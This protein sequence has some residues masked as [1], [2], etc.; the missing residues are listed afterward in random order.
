[1]GVALPDVA[2]MWVRSERRLLDLLQCSTA[3]I[4]HLWLLSLKCGPL[5]CLFYLA[6]SFIAFKF[7]LMS[8]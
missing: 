1:M 5:S 8:H 7:P 2:G 4:T 3:A 6:N